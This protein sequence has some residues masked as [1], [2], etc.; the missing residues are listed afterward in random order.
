MKNLLMALLI[1]VLY[2]TTVSAQHDIIQS[3]LSIAIN[4]LPA[5]A[6]MKHY[7]DAEAARNDGERSGQLSLDGTWKFKLQNGPADFISNFSQ[8]SFSANNWGDIQVPGNWEV[9]GYGVPIYTNW[10]YPFRI[11]NPPYVPTASVDNIHDNNPVG[12]YVK[13]FDVPGYQ[14][15]DRQ[16]LHF[17]AVSSAFH[18]WLNGEYIGYSTGSR[19]PAEFDVTEH[20]LAEGNHLA[21]LVYR[22]TAGSYLEDQDHWRMSGLHRSVYLESKPAVHLEDYFVKT[23]LSNIDESGLSADSATIEIET[24]LHYRDPET[25]RGLSLSAQ[26][27]SPDNEA[28]WEEKPTLDLNQIIDFLAPTNYLDP[29]N[30]F[31]FP[32]LSAKVNNPQ[33]WTA[34]TPRLY[35]LVLQVHNADGS[36]RETLGQNI[37]FKELRWGKD[38]FFVNGKEVIL[39]GVNRHDHS[40]SGGKT[41]SRAEMEKD[42]ELM[43]LYNLNAVRTSHYPND[44]YFYELCDRYGLYVMDET[45]LETHKL[46]SMGSSLPY[47]GPAMLDRAIRMVERDKNHVSIISW[48]LGNEAGTGPNH[49]AMAAWIKTRDGSRWLHNEGGQDRGLPSGYP[50]VPYVDIR[51]RM[52]TPKEQMRELLTNGDP[53]PLI[54]CEYAHSMGNSTGHLDTFANM[55]RE[56]PNF[57]GGFIWDWTDQGFYKEMPGG[58]KMVAYGGDFGEEINDNNFLANG[59]VFSDQTPQPALFEVKRVFQPFEVTASGSGYRV[60]NHFDFLNLKDYQVRVFAVGPGGKQAIGRALRI[61]LAPGERTIIPGV[62]IP[63]GTHQLEFSLVQPEGSGFIPDGYEIGFVQLPVGSVNPNAF[64]EDARDGVADRLRIRRRGNIQQISNNQV[65]ID[66]DRVTGNIIGYEFMGQPLFLSPLTPNFWR[67]PTDND[68]PAGLISSYEAWK[69]ATPQALKGKYVQISTEESGGRLNVTVNRAYQGGQALETI[70]YVVH[71][72][73]QLDVNARLQ[74]ADG[75]DLPG[76]FRYGMQTT[77]SKQIMGAEWYG[78]GPHEAYAD[79]KHSAR[80]GL[81]SSTVKDLYTPYILPQE[82]GNRMDVSWLRLTDGNFEVLAPEGQHFNFSL[83]PASQ[84]DIIMAKH[85]SEIPN[86]DVYTLNLDYGQIGVGGDNS[87]MP[88]AGP[89]PEHL[90]PMDKS[91]AYGFSIVPKP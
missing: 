73:G 69:D 67:P 82:N 8:P 58:K 49:A 89:Y 91:Y 47:F 80:F 43:K 7:V 87:W 19:T 41:V 13:R 40:L 37:G 66:I 26:L 75:A 90:L 29:Y 25:A 34:E 71:P 61:D 27:Y 1:N 38:G 9:Q 5:H 88:N 79:R 28:L 60:T 56:Y 39:F 54:Y 2:L 65:Q 32:T 84:E 14:T 50:D 68:K 36:V 81:H 11:T 45:N 74:P 85:N 12:H 33:L 59:L 70:H 21:V 72:N 31:R 55:F 23:T 52:Y 35:R 44:P 53:R 77:V 4:R 48:S 63:G 22:Y 18:L 3:P 24:K 42:V 17:G 10:K 20:L 62:K 16:V 51:S 83:W 86:R 57:V 78:R 15:D 30:T 46:S 64:M 6:T 76:L